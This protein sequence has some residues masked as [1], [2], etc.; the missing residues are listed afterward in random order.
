MINFQFVG[1]MIMTPEGKRF[2]STPVSGNGSSRPR[3][4]KMMP[5][6]STLSQYESPLTHK[7]R[8]SISDAGLLSISGSYLDC[9]VTPDKDIFSGSVHKLL[10]LNVCSKNLKIILLILTIYFT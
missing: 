7:R 2:Q 9:T 8:S 5:H 4:R 3:K 1:S 10:L 6:K